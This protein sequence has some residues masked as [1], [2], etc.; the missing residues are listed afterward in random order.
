MQNI[1]KDEDA[2]LP[3]PIR[4][5]FVP[6]PD[7]I[8]VMIDY[9]QMEFRL[10][11]DYAGELEL[12]EQIIDGHDPHQATAELVNIPR[13]PAKTLNF[14]LLYGMGI[15]KL[16]LQIGVPVDEAARFKYKYF[17]ALPKVQMFLRKT[18]KRA[19]K[20]SLVR[21]WLGRA[22]HFPDP[23]FAYKAANAIIQGGCASVVKIAMVRLGKLLEGKK[24]RM[25]LQVHDELIFEVHKDE[26]YLVEKLQEIM[27]TVYPYRHIP[28]TCSVSHSL[29]SWGEPV[30]GFPED[31]K[32]N[33]VQNQSQRRS[34]R[35]IG[36][37]SCDLVH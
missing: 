1:S 10:M 28:L 36:D 30:E 5:A 14:G 29:K 2:E 12:I 17:D 26:L 3:F 31:A 23:E 11:L 25:L 22:F 6:R 24:S 16:A 34:E 9:N 19:E 35:I 4:R 15:K 33:Q 8:F 27:E 13:K 37:G 32:R 7:Y 20:A 21:D 18:S